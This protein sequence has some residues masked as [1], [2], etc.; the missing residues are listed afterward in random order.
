MKRILKMNKK[1]H[2]NITKAVS[3]KCLLRLG[4]YKLIK[5]I[6]KIWAKA[7]YD[8]WLASDDDPVVI[9]VGTVTIQRTGYTHVDTDEE[10]D[11]SLDK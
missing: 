2:G 11:I 4:C 7:A 10:I 3:P 5:H 1:F 6:F 8:G 9:Y